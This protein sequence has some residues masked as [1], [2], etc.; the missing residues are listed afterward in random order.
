MWLATKAL[1]PVHTRFDVQV[2]DV[3]SPALCYYF[4]TSLM[5]SDVYYPCI[6]ADPTEEPGGFCAPHSLLLC[7]VHRVMYPSR[8]SA[9]NAA[10]SN[11][12]ECTSDAPSRRS[13]LKNR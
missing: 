4:I 5:K 6:R 8:C 12:K 13:V 9:V 11:S 3:Y 2:S 10:N 7:E 1:Q